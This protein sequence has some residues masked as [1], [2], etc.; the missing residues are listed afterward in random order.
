[1]TKTATP[2]KLIP[3]LRVVSKSPMGNFR[4]A[5]FVFTTEPTL[6]PMASLDKAQMAA[7]KATPVLDVTETTMEAPEADKPEGEAS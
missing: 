4:R 5:G 1:M 3:A 2:K 6:I 7:I